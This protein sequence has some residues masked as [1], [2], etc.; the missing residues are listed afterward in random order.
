MSQR[1]ASLL[2]L[3][4][5]LAGSPAAADDEIV[6]DRPDVAESSETVGRWRL[7]LETGFDVETTKTS[8]GRVAS[9]AVPTKIRF[10]LHDYV[11]IHVESD[12]LA[13]ERATVNGATTTSSGLADIDV[14]GKVH[15]LDQHGAFPSLGVL[16]AMTLPT[17]NEGMGDGVYQLSSTLAAD[18]GIPC[19]PAWGV[20]LNV[21]VTIPL[22]DDD[23][24]ADLFRYA[25]AVGRTW[26]PFFPPLR[27]YVELFGE[28]AFGGGE[29][30]LYVDG[31]FSLLV[32]PWLQ[33]DLNAR[34]GL[35]DAAADVGGGLGVSFKI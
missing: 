8:A 4:L 26:A 1:I 27:T 32:R 9:I 21:G 11:E 7:Q 30:A 3:L 23:A 29:T 24:T 15:L 16:V 13:H 22:D 12:W 17:A 31:G 10:G 25:L 33:L 18:W 35:T 19:R 6:T 34:V 28:T 5:L 20:G 2:S 14:G